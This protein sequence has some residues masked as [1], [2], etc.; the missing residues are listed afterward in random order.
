M[1]L[2]V[3]KIFISHPSNKLRAAYEK[4][5][6]KNNSLPRI[7]GG[8]H[9]TEVYPIITSLKYSKQISLPTSTQS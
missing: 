8:G 1:Y 3:L 4:V 5:K 6:R 2:S 7:G 9:A